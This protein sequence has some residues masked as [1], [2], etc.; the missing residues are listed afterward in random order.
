[1]GDSKN[2]EN[3]LNELNALQTQF[4]NMQ[5]ISKPSKTVKKNTDIKTNLTSKDIDNDFFKTITA[6]I[7]KDKKITK[8]NSEDKKPLFTLDKSTITKATKKAEVKP[9]TIAI[10][11]ET[12]I[13]L[14]ILKKVKKA[15]LN[16]DI[17]V[18][19]IEAETDI[20]KSDIKKNIEIE[21]SNETPNLKLEPELKK[22]QINSNIS[23]L[24]N[25][26]SNELNN[27][28]KIQT[29]P[30]E[31]YLSIKQK[32]DKIKADIALRE[33]L[34]EKEAER[35]DK[36]KLYTNQNKTAKPTTNATQKKLENPTSKIE[37][38]DKKSNAKP[39]KKQKIKPAVTE[40]N[41]IPTKQK[42]GT[43]ILTVSIIILVIALITVTWFLY[44]F[45]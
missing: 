7:K 12:H 20:K 30:S 16:K 6:P 44:G 42:K 11:N 32:L 35:V 26:I 4:N 21:A 31:S 25:K 8:P 40:I 45:Y 36:L 22:D 15:E 24:Q 17:K 2:I 1:M 29:T 38:E 18:T 27:D 23:N 13:D 43:D 28:S 41:T 5:P 10:D 9:I 33:K 14:G 19:N 37:K 39:I 3:L 34:I